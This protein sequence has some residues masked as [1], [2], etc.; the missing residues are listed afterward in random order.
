[1]N[2]IKQSSYICALFFLRLITSSQAMNLSKPHDIFFRPPIAPHNIFMQSYAW[3]EC[4]LKQ[5][6]YN[7]DNNSTNVLTYLTCDQNALT[8]LNGFDTASKIGQTHA[9][10]LGVVNDGTRGYYQVSGDLSIPVNAALAWRLFFEHYISLGIYLPIKTMHLKNSCWRSLTQSADYQDA[11]VNTVITNDFFNTVYTL[12]DGLQLGNWSR[13]GVGDLEV[14]VEFVRNYE[15]QKP[16]LKN[17]LV[18]V[19]AGLTIPTGLKSDPDRILSLP[20]GNDGATGLLFAGGLE[21]LYGTWF[22]LGLDVELI[23]L[24]N[25]THTRRIKTAIDQTELLL[26]AK[27]AVNKDWGMQQQFTLFTECDH[28]FKGFSF[29]A[30]YRFF[31]QG[32]STVA[33][34]GNQYSSLIANTARSLEDFTAHDMLFKLSYDFREDFNRVNPS[35]ALF[36]RIPVNGKRAIVSHTFGIMASVDF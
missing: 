15:Q 30:G 5:T 22:K 3:I 9:Q 16:M 36:A 8:M 26:L 32:D 18:N 24:F 19:R 27:T 25:N 31:K 13:S 6:A 34:C 11:L 35:F 1:M 12:G 2:G 23:H 4:G 21:L 17:V 10:L 14:I 7:T 28:F 20:F 29:K 33:L